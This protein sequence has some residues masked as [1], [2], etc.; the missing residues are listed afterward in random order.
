M[1]VHFDCKHRCHIE[2]NALIAFILPS[3]WQDGAESL[4]IE[5][6]CCL[7]LG[8]LF[9]VNFDTLDEKCPKDWADQKLNF[10]S[11]ANKIQYKSSNFESQGFE[12]FGFKKFT[13]CD[14][15]LVRNAYFKL[16]FTPWSK[17]LEVV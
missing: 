8:D 7:W 1:V 2:T 3:R 5:T 6:T 14:F 4:G 10:L 11:N 9:S 15:Y 17:N 12:S 13:S 16:H